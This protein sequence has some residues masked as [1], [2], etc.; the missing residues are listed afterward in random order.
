MRESAEPAGFTLVEVLV[1]MGLVAVMAVVAAEVFLV[2][3]RLTHDARRATSMTLLAAQKLEQLR[4]LR[5]STDDAGARDDDRTTDW[6]SSTPEAGGSGLGASPADS[7]DRDEA[8]YVDYLDIGGQWVGA[9][10]TPPPG[11][12][13]T[14][15]WRI[16]PLAADPDNGVVLEVLVMSADADRRS[17]GDPDA[18]SAAALLTR[19]HL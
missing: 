11:A 15:R 9:G 17:A 10:T 8:G 12:A 14:R 16:S 3:A 5:Y 1:A 18:A 6:R 13:Y 2:A 19:R 4:A 7:L